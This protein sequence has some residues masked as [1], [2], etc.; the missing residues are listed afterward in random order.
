MQNHDHNELYALFSKLGSRA[1]ILFIGLVGKISYELLKGKKLKWYHWLGMTGISLFV[2]IMSLVWCDIY[3]MQKQ[4]FFIGPVATLM[5]HHIV[6]FLVAKH[7]EILTSL[8]NSIM[9][10]K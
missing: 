10:K 7:K 8:F 1:S 5:G 4:S 2:G 3:G 9:K 6:V